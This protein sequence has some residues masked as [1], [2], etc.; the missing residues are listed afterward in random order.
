MAYNRYWLSWQRNIIAIRCLLLF[1]IILSR[2]QATTRTNAY[3]GTI[4]INCYVNAC[5]HLT[6]IIIT[7]WCDV[8]CNE[9]IKFPTRFDSDSSDSPLLVTCKYWRVHN[10]YVP[11]L[12]KLEPLL[13]ALLL[14]ISTSLAT[15]YL[16]LERE[17]Y[18]ISRE[19]DV[20]YHQ[21][22]RLKP[23]TL[24]CVF[25]RG[26]HYRYIIWSSYFFAYFFPSLS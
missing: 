5:K 1:A 23:C 15:G 12:S 18:C 3:S 25:L 22:T 10:S 14:L 24:H 6:L 9:Y 21:Y 7:L 20:L 26:I 8:R 17:T 16:S 19:R 4:V 2:K 11:P 13:T